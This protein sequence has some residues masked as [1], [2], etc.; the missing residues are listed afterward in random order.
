MKGHVRPLGPSAEENANVYPGADGVERVAIGSDNPFAWMEDAMRRN[1]VFS[2][3]PFEQD[4]FF[5]ITEAVFGPLG[6]MFFGSPFLPVLQLRHTVSRERCNATA[7]VTA[8]IDF[9]YIRSCAVDDEISVC[10]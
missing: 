8:Y 10:A 9:V 3:T 1:F 5:N 7:R 6:S 4:P 2:T